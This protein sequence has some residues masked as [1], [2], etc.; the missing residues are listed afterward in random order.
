M[1]GDR[2]TRGTVEGRAYLDPRNLARR[3]ADEELS[4]TLAEIYAEHGEPTD[5]ERARARRVLGLNA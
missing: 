5:D 1:R 2:P 3:D 4:E